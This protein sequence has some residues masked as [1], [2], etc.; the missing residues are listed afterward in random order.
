MERQIRQTQKKKDRL[1]EGRLTG[2]DKEHKRME[3]LR[4]RQVRRKE[5]VTEWDKDRG[6]ERNTYRETEKAIKK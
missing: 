1:E 3:R 5:K 2:R 6:R 4:G